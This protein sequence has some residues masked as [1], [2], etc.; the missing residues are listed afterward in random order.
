MQLMRRLG[1]T[2]LS[3][4]TTLHRAGTNNITSNIC[5]AAIL[6]ISH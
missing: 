2:L 3:S 1:W 6:E 5:F 4:S